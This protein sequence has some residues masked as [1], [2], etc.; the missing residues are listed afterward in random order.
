MKK[1]ILAL[2]VAGCSI[3]VQAKD[4]YDV[5]GNY[6]LPADM[7]DCKIYKMMDG[8][9]APIL[10]VTKCPMSK[11]STTFTQKNPTNTILEYSD[12]DQES[13]VIQM[14]GKRYMEIK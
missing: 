14:N 12:D 1:L 13:T 10:F 3:S 6:I 8:V 9:F 5:T 2:V 7:A 11:T 4:T